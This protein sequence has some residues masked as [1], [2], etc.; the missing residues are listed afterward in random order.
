MTAYEDLKA[1]VKRCE[2]NVPVKRLLPALK[3]C[4]GLGS[5]APGQCP[6]NRPCLRLMGS[7]APV[8]LSP[9]KGHACAREPLMGL[10]VAPHNELSVLTHTPPDETATT[11]LPSFVVCV[12]ILRDLFTG[13]H[14]F[15][16]SLFFSFVF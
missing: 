1:R 13:N 5:G 6:G 3:P 16:V 7:G 12:L 2:G 9:K 15:L 14:V 11:P 10:G 8:A 4:N